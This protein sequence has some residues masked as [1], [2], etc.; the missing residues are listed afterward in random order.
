MTVA[1][2]VA[3]LMTLPQDLPIVSTDVV[4][5]ELGIYAYVRVEQGSIEV[6][7]IDQDDIDY[8]SIHSGHDAITNTG[9]A[10]RI[11]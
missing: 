5:G 9:R 10:V 6:V 4:N 7:D 11:C 1:E 2:L 3:K 8:S